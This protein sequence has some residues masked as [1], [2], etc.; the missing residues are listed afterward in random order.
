MK[1]L[2][3]NLSSALEELSSEL[4]R[5]RI[6]SLLEEHTA[7]ILMESEIANNW[8][9]PNNGKVYSMAKLDLSRL[10]D[11]LD[12]FVMVSKE[13]KLFLRNSIIQTHSS[14]ANETIN[15]VALVKENPDSQPKLERRISY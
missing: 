7:T 2:A 5:S 14:M 10:T 13:D 1:R 4:S 15:S 6:N 8:S 3:T 9:N 11:K 12:N